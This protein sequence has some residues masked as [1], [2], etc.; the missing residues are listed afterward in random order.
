MVV[1]VIIAIT[2]AEKQKKLNIK[3]KALFGLKTC[4]NKS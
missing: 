3:C 4:P 2:A 1:A